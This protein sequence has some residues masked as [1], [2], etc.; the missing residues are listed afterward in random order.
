M[1]RMLVEWYPFS[2][3]IAAEVFSTWTSFWSYR[4]GSLGILG[5]RKTKFE[6][7]FDDIA[8]AGYTS[9]VTLPDLRD[10]SPALHLL[11]ARCYCLLGLETSSGYPSRR[12]RT[13][14]NPTT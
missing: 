13:L 2:A 14:S 9:S 8:R 3:K 5:T 11:R 10:H 12:F 1:S 4:E 6:R 7:T